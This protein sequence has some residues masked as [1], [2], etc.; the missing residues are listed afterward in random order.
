MPT[1]PVASLPFSEPHHDRKSEKQFRSLWHTPH[2]G[3]MNQS[4]KSELELRRTRDY[5]A[6]R[7]LALGSGLEDGPFI[8][9]VAAFGAYSGDELVGCVALKHTNSSFCVEWLAVSERLRGRGLGRRLISEVEREARQRGAEKLWALAR[10]PGF[11]KK[12]GFSLA[13]DVQKDGPTLSNCIRCPQYMRTCK[14]AIVV[15]DL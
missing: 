15:K 4:G 7:R 11:F 8:D 13:E 3:T 1:I 10:A 2:S 9:V 12:N 5:E 6:V 14:P